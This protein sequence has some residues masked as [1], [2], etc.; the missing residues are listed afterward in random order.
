MKL[1]VIAAT[2]HELSPLLTN[3]AIQHIGTSNG[4][5]TLA[6]NNNKPFDV[7][8]TGVGMQSTIFELTKTLLSTPYDLVI[9]AGIGGAF[10]RDLSIGQ[11]VSI[12]SDRFAQSGAEDDI[13][14]LDVFELN[15]LDPDKSPFSGG[16]LKP[17]PLPTIEA[18]GIPVCNAITVETVLGN[19]MSI[20]RYRN[21]YKPDI[22]SMEGAAAFF[23]CM[24]LNVACVQLRAISNYVEK[25]NKANWNI[26][27]A[28]EQL[29][30]KLLL[31]INSIVK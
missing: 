23:V 21:K 25:R 20:M 27:L 24:Q 30:T 10:N 6:I 26:A 9:Q 12:Q 22:E 5:T 18:L 8:I 19:E 28:V 17:N 29:N 7:L 13:N 31:L 4:I 1:L 11:V 2:R 16:W 15:L 14:F 3:D